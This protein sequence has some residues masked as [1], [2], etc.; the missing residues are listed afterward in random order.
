ME[1]CPFVGS[2]LNFCYFNFMA[3]FIFLEIASMAS[4]IENVHF[5]TSKIHNLVKIKK[6]LSIKML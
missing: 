6:S 3:C 2:Y 5:F 1:M 4:K